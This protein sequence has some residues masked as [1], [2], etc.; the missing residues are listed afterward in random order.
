VR[1]PATR[2]ADVAEAI[3][4][5]STGASAAGKPVLAVFMGADKPPDLG[6]ENA[7]VPR[8]AAPEEAARALVH[9]LRHSR[10]RAAHPDPPPYLEGLDAD[11]AAA[12]VARAL[13]AGGGWLP[14]AS[15]VALLRS[16][17]L[18]FAGGAVA[19]SAV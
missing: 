4:S 19:R 8:F 10:R 7:G 13:G 14:P 1:P 3:D 18:P 2:A 5:A 17:G 16:F 9:A 12:I 6:P 11:L 15:V